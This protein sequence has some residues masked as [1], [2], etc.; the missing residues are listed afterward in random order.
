MGF[1]EDHIR[2]LRIFMYVKK[3]LDITDQ[4]IRKGC[5]AFSL[6]ANFKN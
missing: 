1:G 3:K 6:K 2:D 5:N 4:F